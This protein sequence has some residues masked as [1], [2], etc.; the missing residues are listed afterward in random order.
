MSINGCM[1]KQNVV[2]ACNEISFC[3][4]EESNTI[5]CYNM[6][7]LENIMQVKEAK[8][9]WLYH[10]VYIRHKSIDIETRQ[11]FC[12][13]LERGTRRMTANRYRASF[14]GGGNVPELVVMVVSI[15]NC[16][17]PMNY[18]LLK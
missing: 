12:R 4:K 10:S 13:G 8:H 3:H 15:V 2:Y 5:T 9:N 14:G 1:H 11:F 17:K 18:T 7:D 6:D 16:S